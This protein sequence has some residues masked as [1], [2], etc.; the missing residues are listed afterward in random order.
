M[1]QMFSVLTGRHHL[2]NSIIIRVCNKY[3]KPEQGWSEDV[4]YTA[5]VTFRKFS[6]S[7]DLS[8]YNRDIHDWIIWIGGAVWTPHN[9]AEVHSRGVETENSL[10]YT[11]G[12][13]KAH[14]GINT[15]YVLAT[16]VAVRYIQ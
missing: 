5:K 2:M 9:I 15:S 8:V 10:V 16:T 6:L 1:W 13:W 3:L 11:A 14:I 7:H 12:K 4:G